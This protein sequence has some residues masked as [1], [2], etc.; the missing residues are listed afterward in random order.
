M[1]HD[2][3]GREYRSRVEGV[4]ATV[5]TVA[6]PLDLLADQDT[7]TGTD[8]FVTWSIQ[9]GIAFLPTRLVAVYAEHGLGLWS[10][11]IT[12]TGWVE[13]RRRFVRVPAFGRVILRPRDEE[14][15]AEPVPGTLVDLSEGALRCAVD[16]EHD[17]SPTLDGE[18]LACFR[19]GELEFTIPA[20]VTA[21]RDGAHQTPTAH[22]IVL[23][24]E[25][26]RDA[27]ALRKQIFA[28][29][30]RTARSR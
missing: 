15:E 16:H 25:P 14:S 26:N 2:P 22:L 28:Q 18:V 11:A 6:R 12:G 30:R 7:G 13:Q 10:L 8:W 17:Q 19:F 9:G 27:D 5:V 24:D 21:R 20:H 4:T 3:T 23:F 1:L 29:Q